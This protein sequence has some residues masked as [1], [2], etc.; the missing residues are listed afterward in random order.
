MEHKIFDQGL[1]KDLAD[2]MGAVCYT[3]EDLK[4][5]TLYQAVQ[6]EMTVP[7]GV[8]SRGAGL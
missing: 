6:K 8:I 3:M 7:P 4:G 2:K 1:A 5:E